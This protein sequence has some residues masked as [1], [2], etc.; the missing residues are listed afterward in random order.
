MVDVRQIP[1]LLNDEQAVWVE[2]VRASLSA[3]EK[4]GQLFVVMGGD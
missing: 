4:I 3:R 2:E 1:F